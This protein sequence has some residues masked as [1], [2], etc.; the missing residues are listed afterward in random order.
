MRFA[1]R[2][3]RYSDEYR[4]GFGDYMVAVD[5]TVVNNQGGDRCEPCIALYPSANVVGS[6]VL[7]NF[8]TNKPVRRI[9]FTKL[10]TP[11]RVIEVINNIAG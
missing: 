1:G 8:R 6:W 5:S 4:E 10:Y 9:I 11:P 3:V 2:K 7:W